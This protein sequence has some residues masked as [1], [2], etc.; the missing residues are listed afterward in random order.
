VSEASNPWVSRPVAAPSTEI[1]PTTITPAFGSTGATAPQRGVPAPD[2]ADQLWTVRQP[3]AA[4]LWWI[5][6]HGGAGESSLARLVPQWR[7]AG[8]SWP[9]VASQGAPSLG[10][11]VARS[12]VSGLRAAQFAATQWAAGQVPHVDVVGLVIIADAPGRLPKPLKELADLVSGGVP[13]TWK[14]PWIEGWRLGEPPDLSNA[15]RDVR[16]LT[17]DLTTLL[18]SGAKR[19]STR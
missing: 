7:A 13:R 9:L 10:V 12:N 5:G 15:P 18:S 17:D 6:C 19:P 4:P 8:H 2:S 11:L 16:R 3:Q 1:A 14:I